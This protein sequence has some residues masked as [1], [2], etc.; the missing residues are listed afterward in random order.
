MQYNQENKKKIMADIS[1][2]KNTAPGEQAG[3]PGFNPGIR[4]YVLLLECFIFFFIIII[5]IGA[6]IY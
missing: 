1:G 3:V 2:A 4:Y 5:I 6:T